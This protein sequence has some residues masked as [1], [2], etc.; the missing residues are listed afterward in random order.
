MANKHTESY[1]A[2]RGALMQ[3]L[4][5]MKPYWMKLLVVAG[6]IVLANLAD[7]IKPRI[8]QTIIDDFLTGTGEKTGSFF[9]STLI[10]LGISYFLVIFVSAASALIQSRMITRICQK[11]LHS[12]RMRMFKHIHLMTLSDMDDMGSGRLLTRAT[13]DVEALDEF[14]GDVLSGLFRDILLLIGIIG[15]MLMMNW[16]LALVGFCAV[17]VIFVITIL[18]KGA[19][20][21][22]FVRMKAI[23]GKINGF[24]AESL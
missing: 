17:P 23:I 11:I 20:R 24:I 13:N 14:Y 15:M 2:K 18:C 10:G 8:Y 22:N 1:E 9:T 19:L 7:L 16:R 12:V 3:L 4:Y 5:L 21:R 6:F